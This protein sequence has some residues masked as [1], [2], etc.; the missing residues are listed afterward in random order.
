MYSR[1]GNTK[2]KEKASHTHIIVL[3]AGPVSR[4]R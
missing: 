2:Y 4:F 1:N 3:L